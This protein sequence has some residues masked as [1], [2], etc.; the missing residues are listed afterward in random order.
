MWENRVKN[1][2]EKCGR[3]NWRKEREKR[4]SMETRKKSERIIGEMRMK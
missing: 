1:K 2:G 4:G 3:N